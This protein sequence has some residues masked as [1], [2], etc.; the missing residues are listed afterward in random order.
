MVSSSR[1]EM[2]LRIS[3][4]TEKLHI[5]YFSCTTFMPK[6]AGT[7][8][9]ALPPR[10]PAMPAY[11]WLGEALRAAVLDGRLRPGARLPAT[12]DLAGSYGLARGTIITAFAQLRAEGYIAGRVGSGTYVSRVLPDYLLQAPRAETVRQ[13]PPAGRRRH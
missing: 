1:E 7:I 5:R 8:L 6:R 10:D 9:L 3:G 11:R 13:T 4:S 12:R 2:K